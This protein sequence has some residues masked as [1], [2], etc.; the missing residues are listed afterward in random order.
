M[1]Y[2]IEFLSKCK[3]VNYYCIFAIVFMIGIPIIFALMS[4]FFN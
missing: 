1:K 3:W 2:D 4:I